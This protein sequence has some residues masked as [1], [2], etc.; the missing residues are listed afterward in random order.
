MSGALRDGDRTQGEAVLY[1]DL[2][3]DHSAEALEKR[4]GV[5]RGKQSLSTFLRKSAHLSP[6]TIG[7]LQEATAGKYPVWRR[8]LLPR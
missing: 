3:P 4:L 6:P 2:R 7:L 1:I 5:P 8:P